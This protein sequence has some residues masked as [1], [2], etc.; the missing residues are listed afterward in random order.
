MI[1][2]SSLCAPGC[3]HAGLPCWLLRLYPS[4]LG[5]TGNMGLG[6][7]AEG[8][9][10]AS[11]PSHKHA[12]QD[13]AVGS[14]SFTTTCADQMHT[15]CTAAVAVRSHC[16]SVPTTAAGRSCLA[17]TAFTRESPADPGSPQVEGRTGAGGGG[18]LFGSCFTGGLPGPLLASSPVPLAAGAEGPL[19]KTYLM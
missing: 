14:L 1:E 6:H 11:L 3:G 18:S 16:S 10:A 13:P 15:S 7:A 4:C 19:P 8:G 12:S 5:L 17:A 2:G 9:E